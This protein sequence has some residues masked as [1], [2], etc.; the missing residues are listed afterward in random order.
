MELYSE[1]H[2]KTSLS[3]DKLL[4]E[5]AREA[6]RALWQLSVLNIESPKNLVWK[7]VSGQEGILTKAVKVINIIVLM[8]AQLYTPRHSFIIC[9][10][11]LWNLIIYGKK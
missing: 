3:H 10:Y 2:R 7:S 5:S 11:A 1:Q 6:V 4:L 9:I 8:C